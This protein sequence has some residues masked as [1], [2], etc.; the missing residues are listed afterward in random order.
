VFDRF[1]RTSEADRSETPGSGLGLA[2][3][4]GIVT[5]QGGTVTV[6]DA[7]GGGAIFECRLPAGGPDATDH[8]QPPIGI[9]GDRH[10]I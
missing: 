4:K 10:A 1:V 3:V 6:H 2:I 7:P 8:N 5:L 9:E